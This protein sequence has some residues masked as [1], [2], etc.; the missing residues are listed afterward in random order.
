MDN[1][2]LKNN[3]NKTNNQN[4]NSNKGVSNA[5]PVEIKDTRQRNSSMKISSRGSY[6]HCNF[7]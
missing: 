6:K 5:N 2:N 1:S 3:K 4:I 7:K